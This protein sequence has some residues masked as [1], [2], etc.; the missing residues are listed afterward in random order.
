MLRHKN[1]FHYFTSFFDQ[2][3]SQAYFF[4][5]ATRAAVKLERFEQIQTQITRTNRQNEEIGNCA[6]AED[7]KVQRTNAHVLV[8]VIEN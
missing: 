8:Y 5:Y 7:R 3:Q 6:R 4:T 2:L 1:I